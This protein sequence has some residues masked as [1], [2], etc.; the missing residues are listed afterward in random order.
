M[1]ENNDLFE[2]MFDILK[3]ENYGFIKGSF[4]S[5]P[6]DKVNLLANILTKKIIY[7]IKINYYLEKL[8][9]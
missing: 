3:R 9:K 1:T 4:P 2:E 7:K 6:K 8:I 5:L